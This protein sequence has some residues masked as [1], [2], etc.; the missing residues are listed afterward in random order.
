[1]GFFCQKLTLLRAGPPLPPCFTV[2][3]SLCPPSG[4]T[5]CATYLDNETHDWFF[6]LPIRALYDVGC[7]TKLTLDNGVGL[8]QMRRT[9]VVQI[10]RDYQALARFV[11]PAG[12]GVRAGKKSAYVCVLSAR[13]CVEMPPVLDVEFRCA[14]FTVR[15]VRGVFG[16]KLKSVAV[17]ENKRLFKYK[18]PGI[19]AVQSQQKYE[20]GQ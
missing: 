12:T 19:V 15:D 3:F 8:S 10:I 14:G 17:V 1:M 20:W 2:R 9:S 6:Y 5:C 13:T 16:Q 11:R 18:G 4:Q 7:W